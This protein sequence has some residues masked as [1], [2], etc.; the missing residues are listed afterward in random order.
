MKRFRFFILFFTIAFIGV[1]AQEKP[2]KNVILMIPDGTSLPVLSAARWYQRYKQPDVKRLHLDPYLCGTILT[3]SSN[4]PIGDSAPTASC[5]VT[6][7]VSRSGWIS[8][9]PT[10]DL[11]NDI[12]PINPDWAYQPLMTF[13]EAARITQ[14]KS[15]GLVF[16]CEFPHATP[17]ACMSHSSNRS[18]YEW[19][20][21]QMA[22][23]GIDVLIGGGNNYLDN[24]MKTY[25][26][27]EGYG[28]FQNQPDTI[29]KYAGNKMW[30][31]FGQTAMAYNIDR[32]SKTEPSLAEM[33][34]IAL[35]KLEKNEA[36][37][38]LM[39]EGSKID[40]AAHANDPA[41]MITE[42]LAFDEACGVVFEYAERNS[43]TLVVVAPDHGNSGF[44]IGSA[45]CGDYNSLSKD[46]LFY[47][48]SQYKS[49]IG[50]LVD[51]LKNMELSQIP[52]IIFEKTGLTLSQEELEGLQKGINE[53]TVTKLLNNH[54]CFGFTTGGHTGEEVFLAV[55]SPNGKEFTGHHSNIELNQYICRSLDL[56]PLDQL[57]QE[58]FA[59]HNEVFSGYDYSIEN[60]EDT[61]VLVI[62][63]KKNRLEIRPNTNIVLFNGKE[64]K[65]DS[66]VVYRDENKTFYLPKSL[67]SIL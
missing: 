45:R 50:A 2:A 37:F 41:A 20:A 6:G 48:I 28:I 18:K 22:H 15:V 31:L 19:I 58:Y 53:K 26:E 33:V 62:K 11:A 7:E 14:G 61:P 3:H 67:R 59:K 42:M 32:N 34:D 46:D 52:S 1:S 25:L 27:S 39:I 38:V 55:Y 4:A 63:N 16:T 54:T 12:M 5:Y 44:S 24:S 64:K 29:G 36:G 60:K 21:P 49:S 17:A 10:A 8:T 56:E 51:Q 35:H 13:F 65:L 23:N 9:Y 30:A 66:V 47:N 43:E 57:T 40:W